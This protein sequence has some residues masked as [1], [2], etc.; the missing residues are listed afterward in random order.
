MLTKGAN[1]KLR[2][3]YGKCVFFLRSYAVLLVSLTTVTLPGESL[4]VLLGDKCQIKS[5]ILLRKFLKAK[6]CY[7][8]LPSQESILLWN[9]GWRQVST[10]ES[11][12]AKLPWAHPPGDWPERWPQQGAWREVS[13]PSGQWGGRLEQLLKSNEHQ[14]STDR[15]CWKKHG[16]CM[17]GGLGGTTCDGT[18][19]GQATGVPSFQRILEIVWGK[20]SCGLRIPYF[21]ALSSQGRARWRHC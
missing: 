10:C 3:D 18:A 7:K 4:E 21:P 16:C 11:Q 13:R 2:K 9:L 19:A 1:F 14:Q 12:G 5:R 8:V 20:L 17:W 15:G 6:R